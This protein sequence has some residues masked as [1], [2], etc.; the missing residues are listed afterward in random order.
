[1]YK[2]VKNTEP[3]CIGT[4]VRHRT[5]KTLDGGVIV[6]RQCLRNIPNKKVTKGA[7]WSVHWTNGQRGI[8]HSND[9]LT[10][11]PKKMRRIVIKDILKETAGLNAE[12]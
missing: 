4:R 9:I 2:K 1:M 8:Y 11:H 10:I 7:E 3:L 6:W 12:E 5:D